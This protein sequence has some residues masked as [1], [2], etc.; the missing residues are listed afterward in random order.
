[1][2]IESLTISN[3]R[4]ING[5]F[6]LD[7]ERENVVLV[8]PNGSGKSS[9]IAAIDFLLT[10]SIRE[11]SG[12]GSQ[13]LTERRHAPHIDADPE[14]AWVEAEIAVN[15]DR[16][17][18]RRSVEGR[19]DPSI[20][21]DTGDLES[22]FE[23]VES[24]AD[25]GLHLLSRDEILDFITAKEGD[26]SES[27]RSLLNLRN[28]KDR[29]LALGNAAD[30]FDSEASRL[31]RE[32]KSRRD[33]LYSALE[34]D[35]DS[36]AV[37]LEKVNELR[38]C[39]NGNTIDE[40]EEEFDRG[41]ESPS[42][43]VVA[44]PLLRTDGRQ[45]I[46][47]L[48]EWFGSGAEEFLEAAESFL[49]SC[50]EIEA[51]EDVLRDLERQQ[52]IELGKD[53]IDPEAGRCPLCWKDWD[54]G[55]L[56][57]FLSDRIDQAEELQSKLKALEEEQ[58]G[59]QQLLTDVRVTA[60]SL[61]ETL[62]D[63]DGFNSGSL[64][65][66]VESLEEWE[67]EYNNGA[68][69]PP[70]QANLTD[71]EREALVQPEQVEAMLAD[72]EEH[73]ADG[74]VLDELEEAWQTLQ[75][76]QE[77][78][79]EMISLSRRA[80]ESR[81]VASDMESV[82]EQFISARDSVLNAIYDE[83]EDQFETY[84][85]AIHGD[86]SDF[87]VG[88]DPTETGLDMQVDFYDRGRHPPHALHSEGHQDSM[89]ICLYFALF[90]WLQDQE[91]LSVMMLDDV[92][93]SIDAEH[94][95]P[96]ARLLASEIAGEDCQMFITTHD[97]LWHRHLRSS[98]VVT[99]DNAIQLSGWDI[100]EGPQTLGRPEM[101]WETIEAELGDGNV[102]IAAHQ[103][104][105][106]AEWFLREVCDRID[107]KVPF[108]ANSRWTL[109]DFQQGVISRYKSLVREAKAAEQ[110]WGRD[111]AHFEDLDDEMTNIAD[112]IATD[113]TALNPNIHWNES[114]RDFANCTPAELEPAV[115]VYRDLF[116]LLWCEDCNS[117]ISTVQEGNSDVSVRCNCSSI[118]WNLNRAD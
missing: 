23:S 114:D 4:G 12:E 59:V 80:G 15:G 111:I 55:E 104:R 88:L 54:P 11:L 61:R 74:P 84:Y 71:D 99:S 34:V 42:R 1:M 70:Q 64:T 97:D 25:R 35:Q 49:E 60:E 86:E 77:R 36:G 10:G 78:Y 90:D 5:E 40:L 13:S 73:I 116:N 6:T 102:S 3:F 48:Q 9:V 110:S 68:L 72:L 56:N 22:V 39:L 58:E 115:T 108:K 45:R 32:A 46:D 18:I 98:G 85:T 65:A 96:L 83:I 87:D 100:V 93:M 33:G 118:N 63:V 101:E 53:A 112:R 41:I 21:D 37:L 107:A 75:A 62:S 79:D 67:E 7:P 51:D 29:R 66:F 91:E 103:T 28:I 27:I 76:A 8:G 24:A 81:R 57:E 14:E 43:R 44:S 105:R 52:L 109:G 30:H 69:S 31:E 89:G 2:R 17:T 95:R 26:R 117:C 94:R 47:E 50:R 82:H 20:E 106:M 113:G 16:G 19:T 92:V 38:E